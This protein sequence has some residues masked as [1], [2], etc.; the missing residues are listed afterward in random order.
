MAVQSTIVFFI[1]TT[2]I[3]RTGTAN[4]LILLQML[5]LLLLQDYSSLLG[6]PWP[7]GGLLGLPAPLG[8]LLGFFPP[9]GGL[10]GLP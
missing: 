6:L 5:P 7:L 10:L 9:F 4:Y 3:D 2:F 8:L 1:F